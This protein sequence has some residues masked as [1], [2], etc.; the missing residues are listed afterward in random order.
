MK[1]NNLSLLFNKKGL[2]ISSKTLFLSEK[3]FNEG[4]FKMQS[5]DQDILI[6][7]VLLFIAVIYWLGLYTYCAF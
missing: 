3:L 6:R 7:D 2:K 4:F 5:L 1:S